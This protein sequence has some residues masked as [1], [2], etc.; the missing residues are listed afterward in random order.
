MKAREDSL[1]MSSFQVGG[2]G[3]PRGFEAE[4]AAIS[5]AGLSEA[6]LSWKLDKK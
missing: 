3:A 5:R 4:D 6:M 2:I 1:L